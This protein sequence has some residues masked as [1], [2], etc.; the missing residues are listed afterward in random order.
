ML[1]YRQL[2][3]RTRAAIR[4]AMAVLLI[5]PTSFTVSTVAWTGFKGDPA[6]WL[7]FHLCTVVHFAAYIAVFFPAVSW[8]RARWPKPSCRRVPVVIALSC[9]ATGAAVAICFWTGLDNRDPQMLYPRFLVYGLSFAPVLLLVERIWDNLG[10]ARREIEYRA[11]AQERERRTAAE[12]RWNSL[13][14]R[15]HPHFVFNSLASIRELLHTDTRKADVMIQRFAELLRFSL[16]APRHPLI[17]LRE[18]IRMVRG[19]LEIEQM[20]LGSRLV[21]KI[22]SDSASD[23]VAV[24]SLCLLTLVENAIKHS[25]SPRRAGG[26]VMVQARVENGFL[27]L[28]VA[29]DGSG[30]SGTQ[31]PA[32]HGLDLLTERLRLLYGKAAVFE[33]R[34]GSP[35][36][37]VELRFPIATGQH[38]VA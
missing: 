2:P 14:S 33:V 5:V 16:D 3:E 38:A 10:E 6:M 34:R 31:L 30:F 8:I 19:Y 32:G 12:A 21:W 7:R 24:P 17:A 23:T 22:E 11:L 15:L 35:G 28:K 25:I 36:S 26:S 13:E 20:R 27:Q 1:L 4:L 29:D 37:L 18:E 9:I